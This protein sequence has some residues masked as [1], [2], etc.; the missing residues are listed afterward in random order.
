VA[1]SLPATTARAASKSPER[2]GRARSAVSTI[3]FVNSD[4]ALGFLLF[5][6]VLAGP[7]LIGLAADWAGGGAGLG[8]VSLLCALIVLGTGAI[9]PR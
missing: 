1:A 3:F 6:M 4:G 7:P 2:A 9:R 8:I 5:A